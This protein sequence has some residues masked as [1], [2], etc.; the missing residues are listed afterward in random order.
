MTD[1]SK[2]FYTKGAEE[3]LIIVTGGSFRI[4]EIGHKCSSEQKDT[5][6]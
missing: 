1:S 5:P 2:S 4:Q 3:L 6:S